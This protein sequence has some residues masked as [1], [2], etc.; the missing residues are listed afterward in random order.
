MKKVCCKTTAY[1]CVLILKSNVIFEK[2]QQTVILS[3]CC[4][5][6]SIEKIGLPYSQV[7]SALYWGK[8]LRVRWKLRSI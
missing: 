1:C 7:D 2:I 6:Y 5:S 3:F 4:I 8:S